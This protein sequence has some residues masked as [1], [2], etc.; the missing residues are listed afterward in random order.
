MDYANVRKD[1]IKLT[2]T[3]GVAETEII[4]GALPNVKSYRGVIKAGATLAPEVRP[5][6]LYY[7]GRKRLYRC[8][9]ESTWN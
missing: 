5:F 9:S 4:A 2:F 8:F 6:Y 1:D 7:P 3:N